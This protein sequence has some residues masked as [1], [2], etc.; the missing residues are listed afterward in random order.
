MRAKYVLTLKDDFTR[1]HWIFTLRQKSDAA[2][3][4]KA[5]LPRAEKEAGVALQKFR[6]DRRGEF[7]SA[8]MLEFFEDLGVAYQ[9][10]APYTWQQNGVVE[11]WHRTMKEG[12]RTLLDESGL[13]AEFWGEALRHVAW[14]RNRVPHSALPRGTTPWEMWSGKKPDMRMVRVFGSM[15]CVWIPE[16]QRKG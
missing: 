3:C 15:A 12:V 14:V 4:I 6:T 10:T 5:W 9:T 7:G 2:A 1:R 8:N 11:R 16:V 13:A